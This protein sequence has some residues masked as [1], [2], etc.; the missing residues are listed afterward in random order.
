VTNAARLE[1]D[2]HLAGARLREI[3]LLDDEWLPELLQHCR[4]HP[5]DAPLLSPSVVANRLGRADAAAFSAYCG[6]SLPIVSHP[7]LYATCR[8]GSLAASPTPR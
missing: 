6:G 1:A 3:D 8:D 7:A 2:E 4:L 5:H